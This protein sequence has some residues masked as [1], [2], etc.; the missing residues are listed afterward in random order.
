MPAIVT[1]I[2]DHSCRLSGYSSRF[3]ITACYFTYLTEHYLDP[4]AVWPRYP[5]FFLFIDPGFLN[6]DPPGV[7]AILCSKAFLILSWCLPILFFYYPYYI[8][9][10]LIRSPLWRQF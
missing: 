10:D 7:D 1:N 8:S 4:L 5:V 3:I 6:P 2:Y 9:Y